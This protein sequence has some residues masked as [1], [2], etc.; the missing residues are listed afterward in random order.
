MPFV[1]VI[2]HHLTLDEKKVDMK[3]VGQPEYCVLRMLVHKFLRNAN[4]TRG[5]HWSLSPSYVTLR[6]D[7]R[8]LA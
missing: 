8:P 2:H 1:L 6:P 7:S 5:P 3:L 4:N